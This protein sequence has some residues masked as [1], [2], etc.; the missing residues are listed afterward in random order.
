MRLWILL[1]TIF[2]SLVLASQSGF[3]GEES[4]VA[5]DFEPLSEAQS[6]DDLGSMVEK[7]RRIRE[8]LKSSMDSSQDCVSPTPTKCSFADSCS[9]FDG[10]GQDF[11]LYRDQEG[12]QIPNFQMS[13]AVSYS[14]SCLGK[15]FPQAA[16][17]D[18]F[19][20]PEQLVDEQKAGGAVQ[21]KR[22]RERYSKELARTK[23]IFAEAKGRI[24]QLLES[25]RT[26]AN[27]VQINNMIDRINQVHF[28]EMNVMDGSLTLASYGCEL[29]NAYYKPDSQSLVV[30][31]QLL[32]LPD[33][34][35]LSTIAHEFGHAIDPCY[36]TFA[37]SKNSRGDLSLEIPEFLGGG[38]SS[39]SADA[40]FM[41]PVLP[42]ENPLKDIISCLQEPSSIGA[43]IPPLSHV[44]GL[45]DKYEDELRK[46][47]TKNSGDSSS[48]DLGEDVLTLINERR[49]IV[50][51]SYSRYGACQQLTENGYLQEAFADWISSEI[52]A[53]KVSEI[54]DSVKARSFVFE[55]Q[56][57]FLGA[58]CESIRQTVIQKI[59]TLADSR[60]SGL[61]QSLSKNADNPEDNNHTHPKT[62]NRTDRIYFAK[63]EMLKAL[64]CEQKSQIKECK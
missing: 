20:Y 23:G 6:K 12:H 35:L 18:P 4:S 62:A 48:E 43:K 61:V 40:F 1:L 7:L 30:C 29:P 47:V 54:Q 13:V 31:P 5:S 49:G 50:K 17:E 21:L 36:A 39:K 25:R 34:T 64:G 27:R 11:Y 44:L 38:K 58:K 59:Q 41:K 60:C 24:I 26:R 15:P 32:N 9:A 16:A 14:E 56:G 53:K 37:Y 2:S 3:A 19:V 46:E 22:N 28:G 55:T 57:F 45:I 52:L 51:N 42:E 10:K 63:P 33:A 8:L